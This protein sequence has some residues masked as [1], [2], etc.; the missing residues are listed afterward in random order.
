[1]EEKDGRC[2]LHLYEGRPR[3][4][5]NRR[6]EECCVEAVIERDRFLASLGYPKGES[7][8]KNTPETGD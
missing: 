4:F 1:M 7:T 2:D 8:L 3:G 6:S 5:F